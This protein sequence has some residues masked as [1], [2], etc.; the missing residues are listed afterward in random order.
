M[1][2]KCKVVV[3]KKFVFRCLAQPK[4][5]LVV[6]FFFFSF[7]F[8]FSSSLSQKSYSFV[9]ALKL[10]CSCIAVTSQLHCSCIAVALH[11]LLELGIDSL[12][13]HL[14]LNSLFSLVSCLKQFD[15]IHHQ[16]SVKESLAALSLLALE[17][18]QLCTKNNGRVSQNEG[19]DQFISLFTDGAAIMPNKNSHFPIKLQNR[20]PSNMNLTFHKLI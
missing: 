13:R 12:A 6:A 5:S 3:L 1:D 10:H 2:M 7:F 17:V 19:T 18:K 14:G 8:S 20:N 11:E 16:H 4:A 9:S 15:Q